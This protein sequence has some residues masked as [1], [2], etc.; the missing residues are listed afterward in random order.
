MIPNVFFPFMQVLRNHELVGQVS[1]DQ[2]EA[3]VGKVPGAEEEHLSNMDG[4]DVEMLEYF[5][6]C[7]EA[8]QAER[9]EEEEENATEKTAVQIREACGI[10]GQETNGESPGESSES[11]VQHENAK[12][13][14]T[15]QQDLQKGETAREDEMGNVEQSV[16]EGKITETPSEDSDGPEGERQANEDQAQ[17][18][19]PGCEDKEQNDAGKDLKVAENTATQRRDVKALEHKALDIE[20]RVE[21]DILHNILQLDDDGSEMY[22]RADRDVTVKTETGVEGSDPEESSFTL[23]QNPKSHVNQQ[24]SSALAKINSAHVNNTRAKE[25][26]RIERHLLTLPP[27]YTRLKM[28]SGDILGVSFTKVKQEQVQTDQE[29]EPCREMPV[30][31][32]ECLKKEVPP[33]GS[34]KEEEEKDPPEEKQNKEPEIVAEDENQLKDEKCEDHD[35]MKEGDRVQEQKGKYLNICL[36]ASL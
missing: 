9:L 24:A 20:A 10:Q 26:L 18:E 22:D 36:C 31:E 5:T 27:N 28:I 19:L 21:D 3:K 35:G 15:V 7:D 16:A 17:P 8:P 25:S 34:F 6:D 33:P 2:L 29:P 12:P 23:S 14:A 11:D 13:G 1:L 32:N 30:L 4:E